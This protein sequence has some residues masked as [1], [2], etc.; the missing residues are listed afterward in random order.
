MDHPT[1][2]NLNDLLNQAA[3][4]LE[5]CDGEW[6]EQ[7]MDVSRNWLQDADSAR[8]QRN[9]LDIMMEAAEQLAEEE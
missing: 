9:L 7:L 1:P 4:A 6:L 2:N 5:N 3:Q 8:A